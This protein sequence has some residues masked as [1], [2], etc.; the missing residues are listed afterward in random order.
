M[1]DLIHI[2]PERL[3]DRE[4]I[5]R[6]NVEAFGRTGE[7]DLVDTLRASASGFLSL[8]SSL[9]A[10]DKQVVGH[11]LFTPV[12]VTA[13]SN[14]AQAMALAPL[15]V[16]PEYQRTGHGSALTRAGLTA[17]REA[18]HRIVFVVGHPEYYP[19]FGF[20]QARALGFQCEF[21]VPDEVFMV[22]ELV[23]GALDGVEGEVRYHEAFRNV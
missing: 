4:A 17:C 14:S 15:A 6:V 8:V 21:P 5:R 23:E 12:T 20:R 16:L 13:P 1:S 9:D 10:S 22:A 18:G 19:R 7:A 3:Q 11:I 2:R